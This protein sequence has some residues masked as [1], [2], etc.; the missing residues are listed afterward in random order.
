MPIDGAPVATGM[1]NPH[2]SFFV[3]DAE[4]VDLDSFGRGMEHHPL[5]PERTNVQVV[6]VIGP[7]SPA[8]AGLGTGHGRHAGLWVILLCC[9]C[10]GGAAGP[11]RAQEVTIDLDGGDIAH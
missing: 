4:A 5:F 2:C 1:G 7:G 6:H 11:D 10:G 9:G 8:D 3:E